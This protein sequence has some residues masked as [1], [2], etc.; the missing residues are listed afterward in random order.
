MNLE[1][2][3]SPMDVPI[4]FLNYLYG[5]VDEPDSPLPIPVNKTGP[6][7]DVQPQYLWADAFGVFTFV[8]IANTYDREGKAAAANI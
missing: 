1:D 4:L 8:S 5:Y 7:K 3:Q 2:S 6:W